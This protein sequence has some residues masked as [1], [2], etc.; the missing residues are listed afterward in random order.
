MPD[1]Y[2]VGKNYSTDEG[3]RMVIGGVLEL[4]EGG[5]L[6]GFPKAAHLEASA[7]VADLIDAL[8]KAKLMTGDAFTINVASCTP[9]IANTATNSAA[10]TVTY[11]DNVITVSVPSV[12]GLLDSD[13]GEVWGLHRWIG[14]GVSTG[15]SSVEGLV[16]NDGT[17]AVTLGESDITEAQ[18]VGLTTAGQFVLYIKAEKVL[19]EKGQSFTLSYPGYEDVEIGIKIVETGSENDNSEDDNSENDNP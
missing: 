16:F 6:E 1:N 9:P 15:L 2:H 11:D 4:K 17:A 10:A 3:N 7:S 8:K 14:F 13:H 19:A 12:E 18:S 5:K